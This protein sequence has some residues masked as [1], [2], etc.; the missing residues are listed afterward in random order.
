MPEEFK[1]EELRLPDELAALEALLAAK[2]LTAARIDRDQL[3]YQSGWAA[4]EAQWQP[5]PSAGGRVAP[6]EMVADSRGYPRAE[7]WAVKERRRLAIWSLG[8]AALAASLAVATTLG[9]VGSV[10]RLDQTERAGGETPRLAEGEGL[11][12][13]L[14]EVK[15]FTA[16]DVSAWDVERRINSYGRQL[17]LAGP[18]IALQRPGPDG[19]TSGAD[20]RPD[21]VAATP[22]LALPSAK[23]AREL[24]K[25]LNPN[26]ATTT[27]PTPVWP[28][29]RTLSGDSI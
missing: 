6:L 24:W 21:R 18:W 16:R 19:A 5:R 17:T 22:D 9:W 2:P 4:C 28:W 10:K 14:T 27:A 20:A 13:T 12:Q 15:S 11:P 29:R 8:S 26:D 25:E 3:M 7:P 23:T 1:P